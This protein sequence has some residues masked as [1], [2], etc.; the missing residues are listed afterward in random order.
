MGTVGVDFVEI[1]S[2]SKMSGCGLDQWVED[3]HQLLA[4]L[5]WV[6]NIGFYESRDFLIN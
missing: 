2:K 1:W 6:I 5:N 3:K 4:A